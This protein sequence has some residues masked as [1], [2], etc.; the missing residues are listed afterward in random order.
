MTSKEHLTSN[1]HMC[2][3]CNMYQ[4]LQAIGRSSFLTGVHGPSPSPSQGCAEKHAVR[5]PECPVEKAVE[6]E[7][8]D[9]LRLVSSARNRAHGSTTQGV[10]VLPGVTSC[11]I[12]HNMPLA[13]SLLPSLL[14]HTCRKDGRHLTWSTWSAWAGVWPGRTRTGSERRGIPEVG[15]GGGR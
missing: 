10:L 14:A 9:G 3:L 5:S 12:C 4:C 8:E 13:R 1:L 15:P 2:Y 7:I 11:S 6:D